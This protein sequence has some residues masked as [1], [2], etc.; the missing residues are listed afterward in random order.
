[1]YVT[2]GETNAKTEWLLPSNFDTVPPTASALKCTDDTIIRQVRLATTTSIVL[3]DLLLIDGIQTV[4]GDRILVK[5]QSNPIENGIYLINGSEENWTRSTDLRDNANF[6][7][8]LRV[9]VT[10][11]LSNKDTI[12]SLS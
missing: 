1:M 9:Y 5:N 3:N 11:G 4:S 8:E 7:T 2:N 6:I 10:Q 12:W